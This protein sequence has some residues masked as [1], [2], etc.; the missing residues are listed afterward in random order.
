MCTHMNM[1]LKLAIIYETNTLVCVSL[2]VAVHLL[3]AHMH[4]SMDK[5]ART[6]INALHILKY[7]W[8]LH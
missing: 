2:G 4:A 3:H 5:C 7:G 8:M 6:Y 1:N